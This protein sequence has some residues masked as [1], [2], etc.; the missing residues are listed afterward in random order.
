MRRGY[1]FTGLS[2]VFMICILGGCASKEKRAEGHFKKGFVFQN[3]G[4]LDK[5]LEEYN[6]ALELCPN[7]VQAY[8]NLGTVYL[9]KGDYDSAIQQFKKSLELNY[10]DKRAHYNIGVAYIYKGEA[11]KAEEHLKFLKSIRSEMGD[12]L[13]RKIAES[14]LSP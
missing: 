2:I 12:A 14:K 4:N 11:E 8:T 7:Y 13:E 1:L 9:G 6:K 10:L 3:Q 5:A